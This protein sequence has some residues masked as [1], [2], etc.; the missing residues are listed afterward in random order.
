LPG[1]GT[2]IATPGTPNHHPNTPTQINSLN[3]HMGQLN[4]GNGPGT[5]G[6][7]HPSQQVGMWTHNVEQPG[8][9]KNF[10]LDTNQDT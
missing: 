7:P 1:A 5:P 9:G 3:M 2:P 8:S 4:L 6:P 10:N